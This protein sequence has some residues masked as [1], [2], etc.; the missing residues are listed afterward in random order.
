MP[1][2]YNSFTDSRVSPILYKWRDLLDPA[3]PTLAVMRSVLRSREDMYEIEELG[4]RRPRT[5]VAVP[6]LVKVSTLFCSALTVL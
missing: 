5:Q 4:K 2:R 6:G 3:L 1:M